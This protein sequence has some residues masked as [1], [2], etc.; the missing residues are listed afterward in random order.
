MATQQ[1]LALCGG[2]G[3]L[4]GSQ[5]ANEE[6]NTYTA[7]A[8]KVPLRE[9]PAMALLGRLRTL[10]CNSDADKHTAQAQAPNFILPLT[11]FTVEEWGFHGR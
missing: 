4:Q 11:L 1:G 2:T 10:F 6:Y 3:V 9:L 7:E 5:P 8:G